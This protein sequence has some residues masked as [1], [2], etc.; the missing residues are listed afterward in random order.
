MVAARKKAAPAPAPKPRTRVAAAADDPP[1]VSYFAS[2]SEKSELEFISSG[3]S[4][5]DEALGG[6]WDVTPAAPKK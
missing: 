3:C 5:L 4:V 1:R 2:G 6:G